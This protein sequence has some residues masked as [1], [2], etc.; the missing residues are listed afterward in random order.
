MILAYNEKTTFKWGFHLFG[1]HSRPRQHIH[2]AKAYPR[3]ARKIL[4]SI[5]RLD[6]IRG[7]WQKITPADSQITGEQR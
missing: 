2:G 5:E 6:D 1:L 3:I 7:S 4:I